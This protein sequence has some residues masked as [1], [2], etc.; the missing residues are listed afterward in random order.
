MRYSVRVAFQSLYRE[1]W[2]NLLSTLSMAT[3]L[4]IIAIGLITIY[5]INLFS[6]KLPERFSM[7][8][9]L[10]DDVSE[11][12]KD[13]IIATLK[14]NNLVQGVRYISKEEA[15]KELRSSLKE[16]DYILEGLKENPLPPSIEIRL[17]REAV[18]PDSVGKLL[19]SLRR[20]KGV[21]DVQ[22]GE[23]FLLSLHSIK[24][25]IEVI[26]IIV[27]SIM[28]I[29]TIFISY[30]TVKILFYRRKEEIETL[31]LLG[32][33]AGF[34]RTPFLIE[35]GL[36]G[37]TGGISGMLL[38]L[39]VYYAVF[40]R[41]GATIPLIRSVAF[42]PAMAFPLPLAGLLLGMIGALIAVGR[43]RY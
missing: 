5:N 8:A 9:Y 18:S 33:R 13:D 40:I 22:Y 43:I 31:K 4:L 7:I 26:G 29:G 21:E 11:V 28:I 27:T 42:Y 10:R 34:I 16:A 6:K 38:I 2:I 35:G 41:V 24:R 39:F 23:R 12:D 37:F 20:L 15:L 14:R 25:G 3:G 36:I 1:R 30:S 19:S 32:A 17:R